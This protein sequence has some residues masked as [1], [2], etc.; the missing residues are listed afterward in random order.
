MLVYQRVCFGLVCSSRLAVGVFISVRSPCLLQQTAH[1]NIS[2]VANIENLH[3]GNHRRAGEII[4]NPIGIPRLWWG[5]LSPETETPDWNLAKIT[6]AS[7]R[8]TCNFFHMESNSKMIFQRPMFGFL[9][10]ISFGG[11]TFLFLFGVFENGWGCPKKWTWMV[12]IVETPN[13]K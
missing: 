13:L 3:R 5:F 7:W 1:P 10:M 11:W 9:S 12:K 8:K 2:S 4:R 6:I